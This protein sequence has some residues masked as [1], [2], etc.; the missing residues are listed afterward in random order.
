MED[1]WVPYL[2]RDTQVGS[3][4]EGTTNILSI[5]IWRPITRQGGLK[6]FVGAVNALISSKRTTTNPLAQK[7]RK[8]KT[9]LQ[10]VA[11]F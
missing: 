8:G 6:V 5:D 10:F 7:I 4:W 11:L 3:I 9:F 2:L 1:S